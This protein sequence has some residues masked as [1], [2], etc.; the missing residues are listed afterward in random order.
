VGRRVDN[1]NYKAGNIS[2]CGYKNV[3]GNVIYLF[4][5]GKGTRERRD[6]K[7]IADA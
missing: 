2:P 1:F 4:L 5:P 3:L 7:E 6:L